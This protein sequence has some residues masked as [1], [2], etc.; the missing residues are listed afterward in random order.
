MTRATTNPFSQPPPLHLISQK[1]KLRVREEKS[2]TQAH[3]SPKFTDA[4]VAV[5]GALTKRPSEPGIGWDDNLG[6]LCHH[7][8]R[9]QHWVTHSCANY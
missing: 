1:G 3:T 2:L 6:N 8:P 7:H 5:P 4:C 9:D